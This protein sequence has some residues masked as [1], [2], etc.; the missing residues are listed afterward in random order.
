M[1]NSLLTPLHSLYSTLTAAAQIEVLNSLRGAVLDSQAPNERESRAAAEI[2]RACPACS[3][4]VA[5]DREG[6]GAAI[7]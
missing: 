7:S 3:G 5:K 6:G 2:T 4:C 1:L